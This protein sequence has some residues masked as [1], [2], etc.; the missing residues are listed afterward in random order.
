MKQFIKG[1]FFFIFPI[2]AVFC[3]LEILVRDSNS[4]YKEKWKGYTT[5]ADSIEV[6]V[7]GNS[8]AMNAIAPKEFDLFTYNMAFGSQTLYFDKAIT[9]KQIKNMPNLKYVL[10]SIDYHSLYYTHNE[11]RDIFYH[12]YYN[13]DYNNKNY[14]LEDISWIY[15]LGFKQT[16]RDH[17]QRTKANSYRGYVSHNSTNWNVM[18]TLNGKKRV[19]QLEAGFSEENNITNNLNSFINTLKSKGITPILITLPC[20]K[21]FNQYL[22]KEVVKKNNLEIN[23]ICALNKIP[24]W[25]LV[26]QTYPDSLFYN[27]DH[28]N[29]H[30]AK[31]VSTELNLMIQNINRNL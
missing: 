9:L 15:A 19:E 23:K 6:L 30:G 14:V 29:K 10:I 26:N 24:Y 20:H 12:Y 25:N 11:A 21:Y 22:N 3:V 1:F 31:K 8:H 17:L 4:L 13:I 7:L 28:L 18:D 5:K 27:V 2:L 16:I